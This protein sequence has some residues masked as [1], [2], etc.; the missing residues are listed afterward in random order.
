MARPI[1]SVII[2]AH[3]DIDRLEACLESLFQQ[4]SRIP[5]EV[6]IVDC[7][8]TD[9]TFAR[10]RKL[11][12]RK[13]NFYVWKERKP[14]SSVGRNAGA[15]KARGKVLLFGKAHTRFSPQWVQE[16]ARPLLKKQSYPLAAVGGKV[17]GDF[18]NPNKP[19]LWEKYLDHLFH[20]WDQDRLSPYPAFLPW[21]PTCNLAIRKDVFEELGGFDERWRDAAY[22]IDLC[23][24]LALCGF[25]LGYAP[26]AEVHHTRRSSLLTLLWEIEGCAYYNQ[27]LLA[28]YEKA[29]RL[30]IVRSRA[31]HLKVYGQRLLGL[32][33]ETD[34][35][36][37]I[38][39][40]GLDSLV[41]AAGVIGN[42][43]AHLMGPRGNPKFDPTRK[44]IVP[45][46]LKKALPRGYAHLQSLG[47]AYWKY[48]HQIGQAGDFVLFQPKTSQRYRFDNKSWKVWSVKS[49]RGQSEDAAI[50]L[51]HPPEDPDVLREIDALTLD[52]RTKRLL[53]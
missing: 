6:H 19:N 53:P 47:W 3:N 17:V 40:R 42:L 36:P 2:T 14:G 52:M 39:Y 43:Q 48:P 46:R 38:G 23:W 12:K 15:R 27:S 9:G 25:V 51:G 33:A 28:T 26:R 10:V 31:G 50:A 1:A 37:K 32:V 45:K 44:G 22:D 41:V 18:R 7:A 34:S 5:F 20:Y 8:S 13:R 35:L 30:P 4:K 24:R 16:L 11:T 49:E 21:A 29:L